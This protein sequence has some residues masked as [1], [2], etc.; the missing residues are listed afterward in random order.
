MKKIISLM[1]MSLLVFCLVACGEEEKHEEVYET[2]DIS[3]VNKLIEEGKYEEAYA[4]LEKMGD[5]ADA[6]EMKKHFHYVNEKVYEK[7][8]TGAIKYTL[9][10]TYGENNLPVQLVHT[11]SS[12][13]KLT[14]DFVYDENGNIVKEEII[15]VNGDTEA[16][17]NTY[18]ENGHLIK[19][20][21][22]K[23][24][25]IEYISEFTYDE[26]GYLVKEVYKRPGGYDDICEYTYD[27]NGNL[28]KE[29][30]TE[31]D[32]TKY[33]LEY[34]YDENGNN[35]QR[36]EK[37]YSDGGYVYDYVCDE[38]G[39]LIK[40]TKTS[41]LGGEP[42]Y[43][44]NFTCDEN[45]NRTSAVTKHS[46]GSN[47]MNDFKYDENGNVIKHVIMNS[48]NVI[49]EYNYTYKLVYIPFTLSERVEDIV[50]Y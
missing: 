48:N 21:H 33:I 45:G 23:Q 42:L 25:E 43:V 34:T 26:N 46:D 22:T 4:E 16:Y 12:G 38:N 36:R 9:E 27:E 20:E 37:G 30:Y 3:Q 50:K 7:D 18:D 29:E 39:N 44:C 32:G 17:D 31:F 28:L 19:E 10:K 15:D 11:Y 40:E 49:L 6:L 2:V 35:I 14:C 8:S 1:L 47:S 13:Y 24:G 41:A 5:D